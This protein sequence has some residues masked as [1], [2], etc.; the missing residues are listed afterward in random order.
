[1]PSIVYETIDRKD[2]QLIRPLWN[3]LR[4][5]TRDTTTHFKEHYENLDF[6]ERMARLDREGTRARIDIARDGESDAIVG[7]SLGTVNAE[8]TGELA[9][10]YVD[11]GHR[12]MGI[13]TALLERTLGWIEEQSPRETMILTAFENRDALSLYGRFGFFP[14]LVTLNR[15]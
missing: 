11:E 3:D 13:G 2:I 8:G 14:H 6:D 1:M 7:Y 15:K 4:L 5:F 9:S 10:F 12:R